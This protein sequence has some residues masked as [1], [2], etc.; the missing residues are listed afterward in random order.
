MNNVES[1]DLLHDRAYLQE[2]RQ[3]MLRFAHNQL[4]DKALAEDVVQEALEAALKNAAAFARRAALRTWVMAILK[5]KIIDALRKKQQRAEI[6][7][8]EPEGCDCAE[9]LF[10]RKGHWLAAARPARW[11]QPAEA[12]QDEQFWQVFELC[13]DHLPARHAR[14]FMMREF[15]GLNSDE[16]CHNLELSS[17]NLHVLLHRARLALRSCLENR[18]FATGSRP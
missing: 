3:I 13:L 6:S 17:S 16:I 18:W 5:N 15:L 2:L 10:D 1:T 9:E 7:S 8:S 4:D 12:M 11:S 14:V